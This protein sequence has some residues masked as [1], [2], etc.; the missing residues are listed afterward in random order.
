M[1]DILVLG[2]KDDLQIQHLTSALRDAGA[3]PLIVNTNSCP[4]SLSA[5]CEPKADS[6]ALLVDEEVF[7]IDQFC[8]FF[9]QRYYPPATRNAVDSKN[10]LSSLS[11]LFY[12]RTEH[13]FNP[14]PAVRFHQAKP[15][16]LREAFQLGAM[17]PET[18]ISNDMVRLQ[19]FC[20]RHERAIIKPV[21][22]GSHT[23]LINRDNLAA[24]LSVSSERLPVTVQECIEGDDV[25]TFVIESRVFAAA[26]YSDQPDY[27]I[28]E[29][30][31]AE[32]IVIP[33]DVEALC[34]AIC[35]QFGMKWCA[36]DWRRNSKGEFIF[37]EANPAP[38][39]CR[40]EAETGLPITETL[41]QAL[42]NCD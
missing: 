3:G 6:F 15:V 23:V 22:G 26:I 21:F 5:V 13:W 33:Q 19:H 36:I 2:S 20:Q 17:I 14:L 10:A 42:I 18:L 30:A 1:T 37:L 7:E 16:Q 28:D 32:A 35:L 39:F 27:R 12:H 40:F 25:R 41:V 34:V 11:P 29:M 24:Q 9:W 38:M 4:D 31:Y 8:S